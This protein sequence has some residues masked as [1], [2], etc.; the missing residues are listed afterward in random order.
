MHARAFPI[1]PLPERFAENGRACEALV[2]RPFAKSPFR[3]GLDWVSEE[4]AASR[5][6]FKIPAC[7]SR[8]L[9]CSSVVD[10]QTGFHALI[11]H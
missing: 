10:I 3:N 1:D 6:D 5:E 4:H 7:G 11:T 2:F 8:L 9:R